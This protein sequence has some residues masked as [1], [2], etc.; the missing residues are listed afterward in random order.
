[1][2]LQAIADQFAGVTCV[3]SVEK[4]PDGG[5]GVIRIETGNAAYRKSFLDAAGPGTSPEFIPGQNYEVYIKKDLNF[6][7]FIY[8]AA[9]LKKP[10]HAYVHTS[11]R[12]NVWFNMFAL[13]LESDNPDIGYCAYSLEFSTETNADELAN[14]SAQITAD[15]L[16][17]CIKLRETSDFRR[18]MKGISEDFRKLCGANYCCVLLTDFKERTCSVLGESFG[19]GG[20][21]QA[22]T[23][24]L[25]DEKFIDYAASW[26]DLLGGSNCIIIK[27]EKD[28]AL[29]KER[30]PEW[31]ASLQNAEVESLVLFPLMRN[32]EPI[33]FI[34]VANFNTQ[35]SLRIKETLE[36]ATFFLSSE[37]QSFQLMK[38]LEVLS[39]V[40]L[41]TGAKNRNAMNNLVSDMVDG[42]GPTPLRYG[43]VFADVNGL[44]VVNDRDGHEAGDVLLRRAAR[45]LKGA[46]KEF[47][48]YR[49]GGDEYVVIAP[50][51]DKKELEARVEC[52]RLNSEKPGNVSFALGLWYE[53]QGGDIRK[54]M[55]NADVDMYKDK[56]LYY[57]RHPKE[58]R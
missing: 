54:A 45:V 53:D 40:D 9:V 38:Q 31:Y 2:D 16:K 42:V 44:K 37:I 17:I 35:D 12:F 7:D 8:R 23:T 4:K 55:H 46:F 28:M 25:E 30:N 6:E 33:G 47:E 48:V 57:E 13:P 19:M 29:V 39:S 20:E 34:W 24:F 21:R 3:M 27:D 52:L 43:V 50:D 32:S 56:K 11:D 18:S 5:Y 41:L 36:L 1:M 58:R 51:V 49:A 14:R 15:V 22:S 26:M 10:M